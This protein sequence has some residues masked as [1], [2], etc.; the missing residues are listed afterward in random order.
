MISD[1]ADADAEL[2]AAVAGRPGWRLDDDGRAATYQPPGAD[3]WH[4]R[5]RPVARPVRRERYI[6]SL[7][8]G[9]VARRSVPV[10]GVGEGVIVA[11]RLRPA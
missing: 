6:V 8:A 9:G 5:L 7:I 3:A 4:V 1:P 11:E 2:A 10:G